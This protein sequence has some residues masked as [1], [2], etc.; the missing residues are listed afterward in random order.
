MEG[1]PLEAFKVKNSKM[2]YHDLQ[3][4]NLQA[5][6]SEDN[7]FYKVFKV[8]KGYLLKQNPKRTKKSSSLFL[9]VENRTFSQLTGSRRII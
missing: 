5:R 8:S 7:Y 6:E 4:G 9:N 1:N 3:P 2:V